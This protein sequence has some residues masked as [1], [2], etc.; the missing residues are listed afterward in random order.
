MIL[1]KFDDGLHEADHITDDV[2]DVSE[3]GQVEGVWVS[4]ATGSNCGA[5]GTDGG[6]DV[7]EELGEVAEVAAGKALDVV[8]D[9]LD[10]LGS[11]DDP[12]NTGLDALDWLFFSVA[13]AGESDEADKKCGFHF[14]L[15]PIIQQNLWLKMTRVQKYKMVLKSF[16]YWACL[17]PDNQNLSN[18]TSN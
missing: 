15:L 2:A 5:D 6:S 13:C 9:S 16:K 10:G 3:A 4:A 14:K 7:A 18:L 8:D 11:G 17:D 12:V 1:D